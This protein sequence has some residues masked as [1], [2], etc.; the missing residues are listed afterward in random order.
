MS[1]VSEAK[2]TLNVVHRQPCFGACF[3]RRSAAVMN[4]RFVSVWCVDVMCVFPQRAR[5]GANSGG[6]EEAEDEPHTPLPPPMEIIKD[7]SAQEDKVKHSI[8]FIFHPCFPALFYA[9]H[10]LSSLLKEQFIQKFKFKSS[11]ITFS[12]VE[13]L[14]DKIFCSLWS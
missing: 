8:S 11:F 10:F 7:P 6:E 3:M 9:L 14:W 13:V 4:H 5:R 2:A 12:L 1:S